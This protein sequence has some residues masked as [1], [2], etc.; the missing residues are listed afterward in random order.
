MNA[1]RSFLPG[2]QLRPFVVALAVFLFA[3]AAAASLIRHLQQDDRREERT[4]VSKLAG[5]QA[6]T[7]QGNIERA[8][9]AA[10]ALAALVHQGHGVV[11]DFAAVAVRLL[12]LY[13]GADSLQLAPGGV[14]RNI[15]PLAGNERAIGHELL[16]DPAR[17][18]AAFDA[19]DTGK[20]TLDGP[21]DLIQGGVGAVGRLPVFLDDAKGKRSFWGFASVVIRF[22]EALEPFGL[23]ELA[24]LG[25]AYELWR[26]HPATGR[27]QI[28]AASPTAPV[29]PV[30]R[31]VQVP[32][33]T[34]TL[35]VAPV[36]GWRENPL[37]FALETALGLLFSLLLA[38]L[39][40]LLVDLR[41]HEQGL[42]A[43]VAQRTAELRLREQ[44][45]HDSAEKLRLFADNVPAMTVSWDEKLHCRF[46]NKPFTEFF[47][48][49]AETI[50]GRHLR[51]V[52]GEEAYREI[53]GYFEQVLRGYP[54]IY[55]RIRK[56]ADGE[57]RYLEV[58][59]LPHIG[60]QGNILGCFAVTTDI[61][62]HKLAEERIQRVAHHDSLTGLPNRLLF[63]DR[64][65]QAISFA[66]R[67]SRQ[68]GLLYLDLDKFKPVNDTLGH[69]AGD[70]LL[71]SAAE[72][73]RRQ[74][75]ESDTVA[76][77][78]GDE[79]TV[80]LPDIARREEAETVARKVIAALAAPFQLGNQK[81]SVEIGTSIG[82]AIY[83]ADA[84]DADALV[85]AADAAMYSAKQAGS[86]FRFCGE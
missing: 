60:D 70:E 74:V 14:I 20:L 22:P 25:L 56:L 28:I 54:V 26:V 15:A 53:E 50:L 75:R 46:A 64:L 36:E 9:S 72:R 21:F 82:I 17:T 45:L 19:R 4:R 5:D 41:A 69:I 23:L 83:P 31:A 47:G 76:R 48:F 8:L 13:P 49:T 80:I 86:S 68:F 10:Y 11:R 7:L 39:A 38:Y 52:V 24:K 51:E 34:W 12:P 57:S 62:E 40:K 71:Q 65:N 67:D 1:M 44:A 35:S 85:K 66:K 77:V 78:G 63:N 73:I 30:E 43:L 33:A 59:L 81:Q 3:A 42:E 61:T 84:R 79:F 18:G 16:R 2:R 55:Q 32:N 58:K 37:D 27:K 29:D 6:H